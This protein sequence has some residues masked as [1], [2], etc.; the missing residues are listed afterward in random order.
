MLLDRLLKFIRSKD[1]PL[2]AV[3]AGYFSKLMTLLINRK[4]KSI[5]PYVF[6]PESDVIDCLLYHVYQKSI[7]ELVN[8]FLNIQ[9]SNGTGAVSSEV[10][11]QKQQYILNTLVEKLG[12]TASEED[13]LNASS[14]LQDALDTKEYYNI[15]SRRNNV[16]KMLDYALPAAEDET[17][18]V[19]SQNAAFGVLTQLTSLYSETKK[20]DSEMKK[21]N[22]DDEDEETTVQQQ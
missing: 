9:E 4:Q 13:N 21:K 19:E 11:K 2:N 3:L 15:V 1:K 14:I 22:S 20:K 16:L 10:I 7:S 12:P 5:L 18:N 6:A 17:N 8:K